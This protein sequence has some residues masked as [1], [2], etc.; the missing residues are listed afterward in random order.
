MTL[1]ALRVQVGD[2]TFLRILRDWFAEHRYAN[3][4][5]AD[6]TA[7]A[8]RDSRRNLRAFFE[9]WLYTPGQVERATAAPQPAAVQALAQRG[10]R[11]R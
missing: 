6:F 11:R 7:L 1:Q 5:T 3:A 8:Q 10:H 9:K 2:P 4:T